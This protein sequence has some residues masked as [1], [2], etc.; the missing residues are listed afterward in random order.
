MHELIKIGTVEKVSG[1]RATVRFQGAGIAVAEL[2]VLQNTP[3]ETGAGGED[4]HSHRV[5][6]W[7][8]TPGG[9]VVC[10]MIPNGNGQGFVIGEI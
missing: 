6:R 2:T 10:M 1:K 4:H 5:S 8:P 9:K 3:G 7:T